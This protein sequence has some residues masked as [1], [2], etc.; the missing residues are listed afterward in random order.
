MLH[1]TER[2]QA[3]FDGIVGRSA[4][5]I[6]MMGQA[7]RAAQTRATVL[8]LGESGTGKELLAEAI[9]RLSPRRDGPFVAVNMAALP[10]TLVES[11]LFGCVKGAYTGATSARIGRFEAAQSGTLF[12]DEIG[13]LKPDNQAKL[14]R[15]LENH[16]I[17]PVGGNQSRRID[18]RVVAATH[19]NLE[20]MVAAGEFR[21][22]LYYRLNVITIALPPLRNRREDIPLLL[23]YYLDRICSTHGKP[24]PAMTPEL[25]RFFVDYD[26]PGNI[27]QFRNCI[28]SMIILADAA[29]LG[30]EHVPAMARRP[31]QRQEAA[32]ELPRSVTLTEVRKTAILQALDWHNGNRTRTAHALGISVRTLQ[33][34][35]KQWRFADARA[36][37]Q[38][39]LSQ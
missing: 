13:D 1:G 3:G 6:E 30:T 37:G 15:V 2:D 26:W 28:E 39:L 5:M 18:V 16:Q 10:E 25:E 7:A 38:E 19:R 23:D 24:R 17:T 36:N 22:D 8:L 34:Y 11:E 9:H 20:N 4:T 33:R 35:L 27:R 12:I 29:V 31:S 21:E 32:V 14:L